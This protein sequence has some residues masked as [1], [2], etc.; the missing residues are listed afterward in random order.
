MR[1]FLG[2]KNL[3]CPI[4]ARKGAKDHQSQNEGNGKK[5]QEIPASVIRFPQEAL[6]MLALASQD[7]SFFRHDN[8]PQQLLK[9]RQWRQSAVANSN[10]SYFFGSMY[11]L[12]LRV[13]RADFLGHLHDPIRRVRAMVERDF[14]PVRP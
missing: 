7:C 13:R 3:V 9:R 5:N 12:R 2:L 6:P 10:S 1:R 11:L 8:C 14:P 4:D